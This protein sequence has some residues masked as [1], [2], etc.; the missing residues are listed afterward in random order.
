MLKNRYL[1]DSVKEDL[2]DKMVFI[3]G[4]RQV[5]KTTFAKDILGKLFKSAYYN[6]D[7]IRMRLKA[8][9]SEWDYEAELIIL[10]EFH[11]HKNWKS[12]IKGEYDLNK[13]KYK[14]ILTGS[15]RLNI[16]RR[17]GDSLQGRYYYYNLFPFTLAELE[18][19]KNKIIPQKELI[20]HNEKKETFELLFKFGGFPEPFFK[21]SEKF[22]RR[23]IMN[24]I[25]RLIKEDIRDLTFLRNMDNLL[26]LSDL[27]KSKVSSVLSI[28]SLA[29]DLQINFRTV[30]NWLDVFENFYYIFR[31]S[32]YNKKS[33]K[34]VK[35][36]KKPYLWDW[37]SLDEKGAK[38]ENLVAL[39]LL[40]FVDFMR[41][42][43]GY[44]INLFY[45][46]DVNGREVDFLITFNDKPW[47]A[48]EV[49][50][51]DKNLSKNL[52]YFKQKLKIPFLYQI[53]NVEGYDFY[54]S[55]VRVMSISK[56]LTG[57]I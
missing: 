8:L 22:H 25:E 55:G 48:V 52:L 7:S 42:S 4:P 41:E 3:G 40:K 44:N 10:D 24:R 34:S 16:F 13:E 9:K 21:S 39:H 15:A 31:I 36:E 28:N 43:Q 26:L 18:N 45:I 38:L 2:N 23:W 35:K 6:W 53:I 50:A 11:K 12:W 47:L 14:F 46:R 32:P 27:I 56:F 57:L 49:K 37:S 1:F 33:I 19:I 5:G 29:T 51:G 30:K 17:G 54:K 20:F